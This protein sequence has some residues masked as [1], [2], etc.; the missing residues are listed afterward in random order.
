MEG[1]VCSKQW[2]IGLA[3]PTLLLREKDN[4]ENEKGLGL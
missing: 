4:S 3:D 1:C 2:E